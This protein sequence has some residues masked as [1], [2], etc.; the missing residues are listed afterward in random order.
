[1]IELLV[2]AIGGALGAVARYLSSRTLHYYLGINFPYGTLFVNVLG[3]FLAG[4]L[5]IILL[6]RTNLAPAW[7]GFLVIGFLGAFTTFSSFS[8]ETLALFEAGMSAAALLNI[9]L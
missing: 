7:R 4:L 6:E 8:Y 3:C 1:M 5:I 9:F 2:I